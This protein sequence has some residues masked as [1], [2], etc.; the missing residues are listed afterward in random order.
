MFHDSG[1]NVKNFNATTSKYINT[2]KL[3]YI[4][5]EAAPMISNDFVTTSITND[6]HNSIVHDGLTIRNRFLVIE[7]EK[8]I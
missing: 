7:R 6:S 3:K 4:T 5:K 8:M 1:I 2:Q